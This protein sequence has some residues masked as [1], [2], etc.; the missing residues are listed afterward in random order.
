MAVMALHALRR[1]C[2]M[3]AQVIKV[4]RQMFLQV[5]LQALLHAQW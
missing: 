1:L 4:V 2:C 3:H 5:M